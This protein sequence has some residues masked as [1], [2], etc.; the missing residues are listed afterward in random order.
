MNELKRKI[1][2]QVKTLR[3][4]VK[5]SQAKLAEK[6]ELSVESISRLER[7]VQLPGIETFYRLS[8]ALGVPFSE[9]FQISL[10]K[11][12]SELDSLAKRFRSMMR[13]RKMSEGE[14]A[15][16]VMARVFDEYP[17]KQKKRV[18]KKKTR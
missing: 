4:Q 18:G 13:N 6:S 7:G 12:E 9:F 8:K 14:L 5:L 1:G 3:K 2:L 11:E 10:T 17:V 16:D 15:L